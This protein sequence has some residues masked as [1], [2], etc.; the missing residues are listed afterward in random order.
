MQSLL[1]L[2]TR[3]GLKSN[4]A[5][6]V[7]DGIVSAAAKLNTAFTE[8]TSVAPAAAR[9]LAPPPIECPPIA[10]FLITLP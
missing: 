6:A 7:A 10:V 2:K 5:A 3:V 4:K 9:K 1:P 8:G